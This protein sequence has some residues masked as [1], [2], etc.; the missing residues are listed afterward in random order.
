MDSNTILEK[1][2]NSGVKPISKK[3]FIFKRF[4]VMFLGISTIILGAF[5]F[6]KVSASFFV[7][8]WQDWEYVFSSFGSFLYFSIPL[9]WVLSLLFF[10]YLIPFILEKTKSG[11]KY[12]KIILIMF[13]VISSFVLGLF[14][15]FIGSFDRS[16]N[17][18][19]SEPEK[20]QVQIWTSPHSGRLSGFVLN[21]GTESIVLQDFH[22]KIWMIDIS[23]VLDLSKKIITSEEKVK[24]IGVMVDDNTFIACQ[25]MTFDLAHSDFDLTQD[26]NSSYDYFDPNQTIG[27]ICKFVLNKNL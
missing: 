22:K 3:Y 14:I 25:I 26:N 6:A 1:I 17:I 2:K 11:Y 8:P 9:I 5:S 27:D 20:K 12:K 4:L 24:I 13:S 21:R 7:A 10:I 16:N 18:F 19:A 15:L 23:N